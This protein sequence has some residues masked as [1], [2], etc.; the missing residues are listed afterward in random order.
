MNM[1]YNEG[2]IEWLYTAATTIQINLKL[3]VRTKDKKNL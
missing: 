3:I 2:Q 1:T